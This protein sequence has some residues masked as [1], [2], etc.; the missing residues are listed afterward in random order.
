MYRL[1]RFP[2]AP[3]KIYSSSMKTLY[4]GHGMWYPEPHESG[5][6]QIG[7]VGFMKE[8]AFIRLFNLDVSA[9][10]KKVSF[11]DPP[12]EVSERPP[13]G[14]FKIDQRAR[15]L[16]PTHYRSHGV[17]SRR[18]HASV[19][20]APGSGVSAGIGAEYTCTAS[21]GAVLAL[22][23]VTDAHTVFDNTELKAYVLR[24]HERWCA[25]AHDV[26]HLAVKPAAIVMVSGW[27][28]TRPDWAAAAFSNTGSRR[29]ASVKAS[30]GGVAGIE[31]GTEHTDSVEGPTMH[32]HGER[33]VNKGSEPYRALK[34]N[35]SVFIKRYKVRRRLAIVRTVVAGAG[36]HRLPRG[37]DEDEHVERGMDLD[38]GGSE[39]EDPD[40]VDILLD[41]MFET[42]AVETAI[43]SDD[44]VACIIGSS[45]VEDFATY[46]RTLEPPVEI[47]GRDSS[48]PTGFLN[49]GDITRYRRE[50]DASR[51]VIT[52]ADWIKWPNVSTEGSSKLFDICG[53]VEPPEADALSVK[54]KA[55]ALVNPQDP[56]HGCSCFSLSPDG[57]LL[58]A[59][60]GT[61]P[62]LLWRLSDGMLVQRLHDEA[63][64][65]RNSCLAFSP[66]SREVF[67]GGKSGM[68]T[69]WNIRNGAARLRLSPHGD[70]VTAVAFSPY[71]ESYIV[72]ASGGDSS[73]RVWDRKA[74]QLVSTFDS[75]S[76][77]A[78]KEITFLPPTLGSSDDLCRSLSPA[79]VYSLHAS[80]GPQGHLSLD[81][82][83]DES[84]C[85]P[86][87]VSHQCD[88]ILVAK[89]YYGLE[90]HDSRTGKVRVT[91]YTGREVY[92]PAG[93]SPD[94][95]EVYTTC[96]YGRDA[97]SFDSRTGHLRHR[98][99]MSSTVCAGAYSPDGAY[100]AFCTKF[101]VVQIH[102]P[103]SGL[104]L[105]QV[106]FDF[107]SGF[108]DIA[109]SKDSQRLICEPVG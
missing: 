9:P 34:L 103:S 93:F 16:A 3:D 15:P 101:A 47:D 59:S 50:R 67:A 95:K 105:A 41:Y 30:A 96:G 48:L 37:D 28:K 4:L 58:A 66:D 104:F 26:H 8:G 24:N 68:V 83:Y 55:S 21:Q 89:K 13:P 45:H 76:K 36:C 27:V 97:E 92:P 25:F 19:N 40:L 18:Y 7:D 46:L 100:L 54:I 51:R 90:I 43:A 69:A 38:E 10:E 12:F 77:H 108:H 85:V 31:A 98:Y 57:K 71:A 17:Q 61:S 86:V 70:E 35:Q 44:D 82:I 1:H 32:R 33:Y 22:K 49:Q 74:G 29:S 84:D 14:S 11:W 75:R 65:D 87:A 91:I 5:E 106:D 39:G 102:D 78:I 88:R 60:F 63:H 94:D 6:P 109:F 79:I 72:T 52:K 80:P 81:H 53:L 107:R 56:S 73:L 62:I 23:S 64:Q 42:T 20:L 2:S 99:R